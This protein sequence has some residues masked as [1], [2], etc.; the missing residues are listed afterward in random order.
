MGLAAKVKRVEAFWILNLKDGS[1]RRVGRLTQYPGA[2]SLFLP[3]PDFRYGLNNP[4][5]SPRTELFLCDMESNRFT[6][7]TLAGRLSGWWDAR[8]ILV[9]ETDGAFVLFDVES[10]E[11]NTLFSAAA[12]SKTLE[13]LELPS[14]PAAMGTVHVWN[15]REFDFYFTQVKERNRGKSFLLKF[16][17]GTRT[18]KLV[19]RDFQFHHLGWFDAEGTHYL[20]EGESGAP[21]VRGNGGVYL[22]D[23]SSDSVRTLVEPDHRGQ[24]SLARFCGDGVIYSCMRQLFR[25]DLNG[26]NNAAVLQ[27]V[28]S[29]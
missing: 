15:G 16:D 3:S 7:I 27:P 28:R 5:G 17:R 2:G 25:V 8:N 23:L 4:T 6:K 24:Y 21:G 20:Y 29:R 13:Q 1:A 10:H 14:D 11:T 26:S 19:K 22:Y 18:L 9:R 12:V